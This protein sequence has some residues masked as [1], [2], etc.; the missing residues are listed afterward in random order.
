M[1]KLW[2]ATCAASACC[3]ADAEGAAAAALGPS[4]AG[5][6]PAPPDAGGAS[7][8]HPARQIIANNMSHVVFIS[9]IRS[10]LLTPSPGTPGEGRG[11]GRPLTFPPARPAPRILF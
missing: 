9:L 2:L 10:S 3:G 7:C 4:A 5:A 1:F 6:L 11:E 8:P